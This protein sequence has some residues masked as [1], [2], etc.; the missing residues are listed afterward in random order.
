MIF[1]LPTHPASTINPPVVIG[2]IV[3]I[4]SVVALVVGLLVGTSSSSSDPNSTV[5]VSMPD[6]SVLTPITEENFSELVV[7]RWQ[8]G[9]VAQPSVGW[10]EFGP[11]RSDPAFNLELFQKDLYTLFPAGLF[12]ATLETVSYSF[13]CSS[14]YTLIWIEDDGTVRTGG[15]AE[16]TAGCSSN[17]ARV[18]VQSII[19]AHT[20]IMAVDNAGYLYWGTERVAAQFTRS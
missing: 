13:D 16:T 9:T 18:P 8:S 19:F 20:T 4:I 6:A 15:G 12:P 11:R 2:V 5:V 14:G 17:D 10:I 7:G 3:G 1:M